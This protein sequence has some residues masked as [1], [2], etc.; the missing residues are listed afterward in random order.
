MSQGKLSSGSEMLLFFKRSNLKRKSRPY[1]KQIN[2]T[3]TQGHI[4]YV[5][6][7]V[8]DVNDAPR[9]FPSSMRIEEELFRL[10]IQTN[11]WFRSEMRMVGPNGKVYENVGDDNTKEKSS[12][13]KI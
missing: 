13:K 1:L 10:R 8:K 2:T 5:V 7:F 11:I 4:I 12:K 9:F 3:Y 6:E